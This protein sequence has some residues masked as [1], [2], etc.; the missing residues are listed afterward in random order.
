MNLFLCLVCEIIHT[1]TP[2]PYLK[3]ILVTR[4]S[5]QYTP[6]E[7]RCRCDAYERLCWVILPMWTRTNQRN[8]QPF[9]S[10]RSTC[11]WCSGWFLGRC[12]DAEFV[13][14]G[15]GE[16]GPFAPGFR[17]QLFGQRDPTSFERFTGCFNVVS[18]QDIAGEAGFVATHPAAQAEHD[19]GL[20]SRRSHFEPALSFVHG[21]I[22]DLLK[23][24]CVDIEVEGLVLVAHANADATDFCEHVYLLVGYLPPAAA[25]K[26][27]ACGDTAHPASGLCPLDP[28]LLYPF[29]TP[30]FVDA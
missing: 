8:K 1:M 18:V 14:V 10:L 3:V 6:S 4:P 28:V 21:L 30:Y 9:S 20:C 17:A 2:L 22:R 24:Q 25:E 19:V 27:G 15:V 13:A 11:N 23:T 7:R 26:R 29:D 5:L 16:L 12:P